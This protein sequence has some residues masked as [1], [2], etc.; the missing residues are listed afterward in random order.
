MRDFTGTPGSNDLSL[1]TQEFHCNLEVLGSPLVSIPID[2]PCCNP[3]SMICLP[4]V[5]IRCRNDDSSMQSRI[6]EVAGK[7]H[8][9]LQTAIWGSWRGTPVFEVKE[10]RKTAQQTHNVHTHVSTV[11]NAVSCHARGLA[12]CKKP[13]CHALSGSCHVV[14]Y[15]EA[16]CV[17]TC[18][19]QVLTHT[20]HPNRTP[21]YI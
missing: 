11:A 1:R 18:I 7:A 17:A 8:P 5:E 16:G 6:Q 12:R 15:S 2:H 10:V 14:S 19:H 4:S 13:A 3:Q 21:L 20:C 9:C